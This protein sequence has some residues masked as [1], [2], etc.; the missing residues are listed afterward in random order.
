LPCT[1]HRRGLISP[2]FGGLGTLKCSK[3]RETK[4]LFFRRDQGYTNAIPG[5]YQVR[6]MF[7]SGWRR[8]CVSI[9]SNFETERA[10]DRK[11]CTGTEHIPTVT[12]TWYGGPHPPKGRTV[13]A[14]PPQERPKILKILIKPALSTAKVSCFRQIDYLCIFKILQ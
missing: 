4:R 10:A 9:I 1:N 5:L 2:L 12:R 13:N 11:R 7:G 6:T 3:N 8:S 14:S